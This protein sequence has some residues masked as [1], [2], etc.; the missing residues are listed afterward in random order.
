MFRLV[1]S[2]KGDR[3]V[4]DNQRSFEH[5]HLEA[6]EAGMTIDRRG[7]FLKWCFCVS[8]QQDLDELIGQVKRFKPIQTKMIHIMNKQTTGLNESLWKSK[9]Y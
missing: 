3:T 8:T 6:D 4:H 5:Q 1:F 7:S 9:A 2:S